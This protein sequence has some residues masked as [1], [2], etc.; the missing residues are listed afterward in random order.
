MNNL[1]KNEVGIICTSMGYPVHRMD[2]VEVVIGNAKSDETKSI[3]I[4][5]VLKLNKKP[6]VNKNSPGLVV[7]RLLL[8]Q[9]NEAILT[10]EEGIAT[11]EDC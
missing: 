1:L 7:N 4:D 2:L 5:L 8:P 3:I 6:I 10:L 11:K 9:M